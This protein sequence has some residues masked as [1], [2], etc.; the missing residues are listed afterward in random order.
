MNESLP[1][2][3]AVRVSR[4]EFSISVSDHSLVLA[5]G[6][7]TLSFGPLGP[8]VPM[9]AQMDS[10]LAKLRHWFRWLVSPAFP[11]RRPLR[12]RGDMD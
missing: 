10:F 9:V 3:P 1:L 5:R 8:M 2:T 7:S 11:G 6:D 12:D 4:A